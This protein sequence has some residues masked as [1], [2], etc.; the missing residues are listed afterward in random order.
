MIVAAGRLRCPLPHDTERNPEM[1][2][3]TLLYDVDD[4]ILTLTL[5]R[6]EKLN[7]FTATMMNELI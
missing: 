1:S 2:F 6:P 3:E 5:N 7:A 4:G